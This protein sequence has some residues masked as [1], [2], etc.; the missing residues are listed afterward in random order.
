MMVTVAPTPTPTS[1]AAMWVY[2][3]TH[4]LGRPLHRSPP[5]PAS[6]QL[7][8]PGWGLSIMPPP[9]PTTTSSGGGGDAKAGSP[10]GRSTLAFVAARLALE[11]SQAGSGGGG[12]SGGACEPCKGPLSFRVFKG[13][14][15]GGKGDGGLIVVPPSPTGS[16]AT[17]G[18]SG[19]GVSPAMGRRLHEVLASVAMQF[20]VGPGR[21]TVRGL[22]R[23]VKCRACRVPTRLPMLDEAMVGR[24]ERFSR[25]TS[26]SPL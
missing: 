16:T 26:P 14:M 6:L 2:Q 17:S 22:S 3:I 11:T 18:S 24:Q 20:Q 19:V 15:G 23:S 4:L 12:G 1:L 13:C 8:A 9:L 25:C 21:Q 10:G 7:Q 5:A